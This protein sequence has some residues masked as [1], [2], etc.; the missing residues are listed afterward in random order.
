[1]KSGEKERDTHVNNNVPPYC[2]H[3][4][5]FV[6]KNI[7]V[8]KFH[9]SGLIEGLSLD[10]SDGI[11]LQLRMFYDSCMDVDSI[12]T[13]GSIPGQSVKYAPRSRRRSNSPTNG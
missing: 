12:R 2:P 11:N 8:F 9:F 13:K 4:A 7:E 6:T 5:R 10:G 1:M 3:R